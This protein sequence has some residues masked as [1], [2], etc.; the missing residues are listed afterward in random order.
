MGGLG[1][2]VRELLP[3][4]LEVRPDLELYVY[5]S[6][7]GRRL[8]EGEPW[9]DDV[10]LVNHPML[11]LPG[12]RAVTETT[13][14]GWIATRDRLDVIHNVALTA[15]LLTK[16]ANVVLLADVTWLRQPETVGRSRSALWRTL[17]LPAARRA[18]RI[19]TLS[20]AARSEIVDDV[21]VPR[22]R[23]DVVP[24]GYGLSS[25]ATPTP[26]DELRQRFELGSGPIVLAVSGLTPHKNVGALLEAIAIVRREHSDVR[27]VVPSNP[28]AHGEEL[29]RRFTELGLSEN[30]RFPGWVSESELE[31]FYRAATCFAFPSLREGFGLPVLEAM[32]RN[33]PV[34]V[35]NASALPEVAGNAALYFDPD[36]PE[37]IARTIKRLLEDGELRA[38]LVRLGDERRR[39]FTWQRTATE[40]LR[41]FERARGEQ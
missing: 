23:V 36:N 2:Y 40:T 10:R 21:R 20:E 39:Q 6:A 1:T 22:D 28:T 27:L 15:P 41:S 24:L 35:A 17:V 25:R 11:G 16:A 29:E 26:E 4:L 14:L 18:D 5:V 32:A 13:L 31:G 37:D 38:R 12:T 8:L 7:R 9:A 3:A 30:V 19:I 34:A 33:L